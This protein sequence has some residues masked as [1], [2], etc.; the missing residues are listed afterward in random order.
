[1]DVVRDESGRPVLQVHQDGHGVPIICVQVRDSAGI[2]DWLPAAEVWAETVPPAQPLL[3]LELEPEPEPEPEPIDPVQVA[4]ARA[5]LAEAEARAE[6]AR[7][8]AA[9]AR[10]RAE[11]Q[12]S[13]RQAE[14]RAAEYWASAQTGAG[15]QGCK[16]AAQYAL[17]WFGS[18]GLAGMVCGP[19]GCMQWSP[20]VAVGC[21]VA[22]VMWIRRRIQTERGG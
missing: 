15:A 14:A 6:V 19:A 5:E 1:M 22:G 18:C 11:A 13:A 9:E 4:R 3:V 10:A 2:L 16:R 8:R 7:A 12:E 17:L 21:M 20:A